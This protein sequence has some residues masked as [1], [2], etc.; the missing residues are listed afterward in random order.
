MSLSIAKVAKDF[1]QVVV[2]ACVILQSLWSGV[3]L[4]VWKA[5]TSDPEKDLYLKVKVTP[6]PERR[7]TVLTRRLFI[8]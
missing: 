5:T 2:A 6:P 4:V 7:P 3:M 1:L 8:S